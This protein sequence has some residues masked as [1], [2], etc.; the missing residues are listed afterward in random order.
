MAGGS[1]ATKTENEFSDIDIGIYYNEEFDLSAFKKIASELDNE[2]REDCIT[3]LGDRGP[4]IKW[5][6]LA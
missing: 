5:R 2:H 6:W 3:N 4:W 1:R